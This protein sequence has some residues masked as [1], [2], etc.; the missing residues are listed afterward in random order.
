MEL[1]RHENWR[2]DIRE[3]RRLIA[4]LDKWQARKETGEMV[5]SLLVHRGSFSIYHKRYW[6]LYCTM[7]GFVNCGN[8]LTLFLFCFNSF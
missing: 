8:I 5:I 4:K 3:S 6:D 1:E 2:I 7:D